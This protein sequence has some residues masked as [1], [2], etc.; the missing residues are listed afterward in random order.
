[1]VYTRVQSVDIYIY[2]PI[3]YI[4]I[5]SVRVCGHG[6]GFFLPRGS[7]SCQP[8]VAG[9]KPDVDLCTETAIK[10]VVGGAEGRKRLIRVWRRGSA[11][12]LI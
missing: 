2:I 6:R 5:K 3:I 11:V 1:M 7:H 4:F 9:L 10:R 12:R 8:A